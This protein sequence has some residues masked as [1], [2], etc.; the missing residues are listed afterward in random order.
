M[1]DGR[2]ASNYHMSSPSANCSGELKNIKAAQVQAKLHMYTLSPEL[3]LFA[4][5][6]SNSKGSIKEPV[7][8]PLFL[9]FQKLYFMVSAEQSKNLSNAPYVNSKSTDQTMHPSSLISAI[10]VCCLDSIYM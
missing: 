8:W 4:Q 10:I 7:M 5:R 9:D 3:L 2:Q 1:I 6:S